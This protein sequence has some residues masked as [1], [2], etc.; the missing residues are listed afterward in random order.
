MAHA[1]AIQS[2][3]SLQAEVYRAAR[4]WFQAERDQFVNCPGLAEL[5]FACVQPRSDY[6]ADSRVKGYT[7]VNLSEGSRLLEV[8]ND[9]F[10]ADHR[11]WRHIRTE[12]ATQ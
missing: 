12:E 9:T 7:V 3:L 11:V 8:L 5:M 4:E 2:L 6:E 10:D 1:A